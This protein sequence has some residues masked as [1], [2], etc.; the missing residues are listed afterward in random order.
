MT[1]NL[2][3]SDL[4]QKKSFGFKETYHQEEDHEYTRQVLIDAVKKHFRPEFI[5]RLDSIVVFHSL[6]QLQ[7]AQIAKIMI[8]N[9][10][11]RL[12]ERGISLM[13]TES[14]LRHIVENGTDLEYGARPLKR[15]IQR[16]IEDNLADKLL[17]GEIRNGQV[18]N[19]SEQNGK[20]VFTNS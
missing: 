18:I 6:N 5:N 3:V 8:N 9:L 20:L 7:L 2:G 17:A 12:Q 1:S 4:A 14:A 15:L 16:E 13:F 11:K 19:V 10:N